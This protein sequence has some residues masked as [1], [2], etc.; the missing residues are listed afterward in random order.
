MFNEFYKTVDGEIG[1]T[2]TKHCYK[3]SVVKI[4]YG[5]KIILFKMIW[6]SE[7]ILVFDKSNKWNN[8][9]SFN[10]FNSQNM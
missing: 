3:Q 7:K 4:T 10:A 5:V 1:I 6:K 8:G 9:L 2:K